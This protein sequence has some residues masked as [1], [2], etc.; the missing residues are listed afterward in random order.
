MVKNKTRIFVINL[1]TS[2]ERRKMMEDQLDKLNLPF[3]IFSAINGASLSENEILSLYD[4]DYYH[5]RPSYYS[6]GMIGCTLSHYYIYKKIVEEKIENAFILE[7]DMALNINLPKILKRLPEVIRKDEAILLFYQSYS[8][9]KL[10]GD[11][12]IPL[13][14]KYKLYQVVDLKGLIST[15]AYYIS[16][17]TAQSMLNKMLPISNVPD[18][19]KKFY[20]RNMLNGIRVIFPFLLNNT[21]Q[22]TTINP[23]TKGGLAFQ[24]ILSFMETHRIFPIYHILRKRR[25]LNTAK[26]RRCYVVDELPS[27]FREN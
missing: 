22:K 16:F 3:E 9:I 8:P 23:N 14:D 26:T 4:N 21:Y 10:S 17:E 18:D 20:D 7:D 27:D 15:A 6:K 19:W 2:A 5:S 1:R 11:S 13:Y 12:E 25:K 24:K